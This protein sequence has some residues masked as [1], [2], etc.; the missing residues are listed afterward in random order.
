MCV[1]VCAFKPRPTRHTWKRSIGGHKEEVEVG[2]AR[3]GLRESTP[4]RAPRWGWGYRSFGGKRQ[5]C[6]GRPLR[7][8]LGPLSRQRPSNNK[9]AAPEMWKGEPA[10]LVA[11]GTSEKKRR[12]KENRRPRRKLRVNDRNAAPRS[13]PD[14]NSPRPKPRSPTR[15]AKNPTEP[16]TQRATSGSANYGYP[17]K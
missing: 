5:A 7:P 3:A 6:G 12:K 1:C 15:M 13:A 4:A 14:H 11:N 10:S 2:S 16:W 9:V 17:G 8:T